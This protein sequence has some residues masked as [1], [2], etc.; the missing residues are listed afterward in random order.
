MSVYP[1]SAPTF[2]SESHDSVNSIAGIFIGVGGALFIGLSIYY[3]KEM[4]NSFWVKTGRIH[5]DTLPVVDVIQ[6][7]EVDGNNE[8]QHQVGAVL[9]RPDNHYDDTP[10]MGSINSLYATIPLSLSRPSTA[11][12]ISSLGGTSEG[13]V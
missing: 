10:P 3:K 12:M 6:A 13:E 9:F 1:T 4:C 2:E 5:P 8:L 11:G 7:N